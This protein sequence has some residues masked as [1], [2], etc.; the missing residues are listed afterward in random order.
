LMELSVT[1]NIV[2][3]GTARWV[4][5]AL[6]MD[7]VTQEHVSALQVGGKIPTLQ[8]R[9]L[10]TCAKI[11]FAQLVVETTACAWQ[12]LAYVNRVGKGQ[13]VRILLVV[14][15]RAAAMG[16]ARLL[17]RMPL[18]NVCATMDGVAV[19]VSVK[20]CIPQCGNV[21]MIAVEMASALM[22]NASAMLA[23]KERT[24]LKR[25]AQIHPRLDLGVT[26]RGAT[27]IVPERACA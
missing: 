13:T 16:N 12:A 22:V 4:Q 26:S 7:F 2:K 10:Q 25:F 27:T 6:A 14:L 18:H 1:S 19:S 23:F 17:R 20:R 5:I 15:Q 3:A 11:R 8:T 21:P 24:A 9:Q